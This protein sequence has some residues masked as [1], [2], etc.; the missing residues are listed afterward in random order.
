MRAKD[1][2]T[3]LLFILIAIYSTGQENFKYNQYGLNPKYQVV[4]I[5]GKDQKELFESSINWIKETYKNPDEVI[6]TTIGNE[7]I[8]FEGF[9][10]NLIC[11]HSM[12]TNS[13]NSGLY[14][15]EIAIKDNKY[16]FTPLLLEYRIPSS[17]YMASSKAEINLNNGSQY[18]KKDKIRKPYDKIPPAI[19][20]LLNNLNDD[21]KNYL[22]GNHT[23]EAD[24]E[25]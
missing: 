8:R 5:N 16:K 23:T 24:D 13:C 12:G 14:T 6:K 18:Y 15:I 2:L 3:L 19:E 25:W 17:Q 10:D 11:V 21:L 22:L 9:K 20:D 1:L 4:E 7:K